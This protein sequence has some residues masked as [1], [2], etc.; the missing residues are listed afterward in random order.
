MNFF[1]QKNSLF[2]WGNDVI[3]RDLQWDTQ[4]KKPNDHVGKFGVPPTG[5]AL[6]PLRR[7][8][9]PLGTTCVAIVEPATGAFGFRPAGSSQ[10]EDGFRFRSVS[11]A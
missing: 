1:N 3:A 7:G 4:G 9:P 6:I 10:E 5:K 11:P 8:S 2:R